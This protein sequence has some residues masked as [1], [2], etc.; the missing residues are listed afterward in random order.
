[1]SYCLLLSLLYFNGLHKENK[2]IHDEE[3]CFHEIGQTLDKSGMLTE[4]LCEGL[5]IYLLLI[6]HFGTC[7]S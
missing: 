4:G 7:I 6:L 2:Y 1:M 3:D 5:G